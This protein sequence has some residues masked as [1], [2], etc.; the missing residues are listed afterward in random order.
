M[1]PKMGFFVW[2]FYL[3]IGTQENILWNNHST[4]SPKDSC[5][6]K[7]VK[8]TANTYRFLSFEEHIDISITLKRRASQNA[9]CVWSLSNNSLYLSSQEK[10]TAIDLTLETLFAI[11][12]NLTEINRGN[13]AVSR[14]TNKPWDCVT[15]WKMSKWHYPYSQMREDLNL[16]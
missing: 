10:C 8:A 11:K 5:S 15:L 9:E 16:S 12:W 4:V 14:H 1:Q 2:C 6:S 3:A 13:E 7:K